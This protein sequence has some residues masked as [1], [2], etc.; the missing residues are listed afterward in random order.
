MKAL[1]C[2]LKRIKIGGFLLG[3]RVSGGGEGVEILHLLFSDDTL[4]F[5]KDGNL[6]NLAELALEF[7]CKASNFC[8]PTLVLPLGAPFKP[9]VVWDG[10]EESQFKVGV[11]EHKPRLVKWAIVCLDEGSF[12]EASYNWKVRGRRRR[13]VIQGSE[14]KLWDKVMESHYE[15]LRSFG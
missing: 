11:L 6:E 5:L 4:V 10:M 2:L 15:G 3:W 12:V 1:S 13:V 7:R 8:R 14:R 9:M